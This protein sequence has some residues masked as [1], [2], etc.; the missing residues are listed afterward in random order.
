MSESKA[1]QF[2][3]VTVALMLSFADAIIGEE[4]WKF[5]PLSAQTC[6]LGGVCLCSV[7]LVLLMEPAFKS[8]SGKVQTD[9]PSKA[10]S[11]ESQRQKWK[12]IDPMG[13]THGPFSTAEMLQWYKAGYLSQNLMVSFNDTGFSPL[14]VLFPEPSDA[15]ILP[16]QQGSPRQVPCNDAAVSVTRSSVSVTS[17]DSDEVLSSDDEDAAVRKWLQRRRAHYANKPTVTESIVAQ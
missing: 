8:K 11:M 15:F 7:I 2:V 12:Y 9:E 14:Y 1:M 5:I 4:P 17:S 6:Q 3:V 16:P 13:K 10:P